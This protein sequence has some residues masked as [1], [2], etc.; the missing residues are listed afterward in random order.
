MCDRWITFEFD[1]TNSQILNQ[2]EFKSLAGVTL[3]IP[4][5]VTFDCSDPDRLAKF[6][7]QVLRYK[8]QDLHSVSPVGM[9]FL[10]NKAFHSR[11]G[12]I[13]LS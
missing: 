1:N 7:P 4:F 5:Q 13:A 2:R 9:I 11:S 12:T 8:I 6:C 3:G 10:E